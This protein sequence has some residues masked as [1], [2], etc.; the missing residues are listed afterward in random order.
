MELAE[1]P[2]PALY[3]L[4]KS[5][6]VLSLTVAEQNHKIEK[7]RGTSCNLHFSCPWSNLPEQIWY[8]IIMIP[9]PN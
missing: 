7:N 9:V 1:K 4:Q 6:I 3:S 8:S 5:G 2:E